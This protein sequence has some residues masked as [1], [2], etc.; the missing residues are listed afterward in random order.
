MKTQ[1]VTL[2]AGYEA[3]AITSYE[4]VLEDGICATS[5]GKGYGNQGMTIDEGWDYYDLENESW[6]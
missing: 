1:L 6:L 5:K 3:P 2:K 4:L